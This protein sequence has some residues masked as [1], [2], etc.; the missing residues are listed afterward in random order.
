[1]VRTRVEPR[2]LLTPIQKELSDV[3]GG[4]SLAP[5]R[6]MDEVVARSTA[7]SDFNALVLT[8]F[9]AAALLLAAIGIYG[10]MAYSVGQR[11]QEI[12]IRMALGAEPGRVRN[13]VVFQGMR[14]AIVG[15][16]IGL[17]SAFG[18]TKVISSLLYGVKERDPVVFS[19][20]P[21]LLSVVAL[22]AVWLPARRATR[23]SPV[24]A[25]RRE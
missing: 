12:G 4:L 21:L 16:V 6:T 20:V 13:M 24:D 18:L 17:T 1:V 7:A 3:S 22:L 11:T 10:L 8:I 2:T 14:L 9:A 25:L 23:V 15:V 5:I 19:S